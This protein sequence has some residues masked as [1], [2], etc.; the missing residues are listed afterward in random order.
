[1][2]ANG[3]NLADGSNGGAQDFSAGVN[4]SNVSLMEVQAG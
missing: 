2:Q 4:C 3:V 1:V